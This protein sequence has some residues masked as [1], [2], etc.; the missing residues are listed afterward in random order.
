MGRQERFVRGL[1]SRRTRM[2]AAEYTQ[3][4]HHSEERAI[5]ASCATAR[6]ATMSTKGTLADIPRS[7]GVYQIRCTHNAKIDRTGCTRRN[8]GFNIFTLAGSPGRT[9]A[10][11]WRGFRDPSGTPTTIVDLFD[12]CR[13]NDLDFPSM[14]RLARGCSKLKSS[15]G[16]TVA[17]GRIIAP[18]GWT[19]QSGWREH[20]EQ[21]ASQ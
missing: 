6:G 7:S 18:R 15:K 17:N 1:Q 16:W 12:F 4:G 21:A 10:R 2:Q 20:D 5:L 14:H 11:T 3:S 9:F 19:H 13:R 8:V